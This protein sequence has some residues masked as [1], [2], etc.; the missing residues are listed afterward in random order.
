MARFTPA[1]CPGPA[2]T[3]QVPR[4]PLPT[5][6]VTYCGVMSST[7]SEGVTPPSSLLRTHAPDQIPPA[8]FGFPI[9]QAFAGCC[10]S[11]L[12]DGL[13]R[14]YLRNP[15]MVAWTR[16]PQRPSGALTRFFPEDFGLAVLITDSAR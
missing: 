8:G 11:L 13:S 1:L 12:G 2:K 5:I 15:C 16:T 7:T 9:Q 14:R 3:H 6:G 4:A 10:Q